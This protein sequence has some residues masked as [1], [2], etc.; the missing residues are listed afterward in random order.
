MG[1]KIDMKQVRDSV[2]GYIDIPKIVLHEI[3]DTPIFQR[4]RRLNRPVCAPFIPVLT[5][6]ASPIPWVSIT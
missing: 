1:N 3:I 2:H 6:T 4:L 5:M